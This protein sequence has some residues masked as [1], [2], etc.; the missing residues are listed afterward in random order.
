MRRAAL[1]VLALLCVVLMVACWWPT[2]PT[3]VNVAQQVI[4]GPQPSPSPTAAGC[5]VRAL[6]AGT[7]G[8]VYIASPG[9]E[10]A[11]VLSAMGPQAELPTSCLAGAAWDAPTGP[12]TL[13]GGSPSSAT[14]RLS[15]TAVSGAAC[16]TRA[17]LG[18]LQSN[19][20]TVSVR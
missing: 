2:S 5:D 18:Q 13:G 12:C 14:L 6:D 19:A 7:A 9:E 20:I 1:A 8:D 15:P 3:E 10:V 11:L 4:I 17:R 16:T